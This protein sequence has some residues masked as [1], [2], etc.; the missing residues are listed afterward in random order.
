MEKAPGLV[1]KCYQSVK[2]NMPDREII[3]FTTKFLCYEYWKEHDSMVDYFLL[4]DF[5]SIV[6]DY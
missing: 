2:E 6:L 5:M 3:V 4:H 1:Q